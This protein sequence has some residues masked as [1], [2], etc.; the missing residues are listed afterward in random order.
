MISNC[1]QCDR[2]DADWDIRHTSTSN[3]I[4][5]LPFGKTGKYGPKTG[6]LGVLPV[7]GISAASTPS[8]PHCPAMCR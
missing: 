2:G 3:A 6:F 7:V 8:A 5:Q 1:R 4:Y